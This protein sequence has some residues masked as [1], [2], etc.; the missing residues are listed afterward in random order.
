MSKPSYI[1]SS[2]PAATRSAARQS[3]LMITVGEDSAVKKGA[4]KGVKKQS[5]KKAAA[6]KTTKVT[7]P[8][9][10]A[11]YDDIAERG[12]SPASEK[13]ANWIF[14]LLKGRKGNSG[15]AQI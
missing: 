6:A 12:Q 7:L 13:G 8:I 11:S 1:S 5:I 14:N 4:K 15:E 10:P 3:P 9:P 2:T